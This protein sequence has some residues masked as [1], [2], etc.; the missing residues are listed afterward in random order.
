[1][2]K[3]AQRPLR[4][5][6][7]GSGPSAMYAAEALFKADGLDVRVDVFDRLP[8]PYGLVRGG[9][10][11]DHQKIKNVV[12]VYEKVES[13]PR[14]RFFGNVTLGRDVSVADLRAHYDQIVYAV[15]NES[16]R[17]MGIPGEDLDGVHSATDFVGW[18][19]GHPDY[20]DLEFKLATAQRVAIV[21]NGNVAVDVARILVRQPDELAPTDIA[22]Y[23]L[24][25]LR[26]SS[27]KDVVMLGRR[28]PAQAAF[29][30]KELQELADLDA[31]SVV[32]DPAEIELD[33]L[34]AEWLESQ[35]RSSK[36]N[37]EIL[38]DLAEVAPTAGART[39]HCRFLVSPVEF[40]GGSGIE[41]VRIEHGELV[42]DD[43]GTPRPKG[44]GKFEDLDVD[45]VFK[46]VGYRGV[47]IDGV[48]FDEGWGVIP[49]D[50][51]RVLERRDGDVVPNEYVVGWAKRGPTGLIGTNSPDAKDTVARMVED[52]TATRVW[53][54]LPGE[55]AIT[56]LLTRRGVEFVNLEDWRRLDAFEQ[57]QGAQR[58]KIRAK[59][60]SV[61]EMLKVVR[62]LRAAVS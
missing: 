40:A 17:K 18:Y 34:S 20:R 43:R 38:K 33:E 58:G 55:D 50:E 51:G 23:A 9:V 47:A 27:V 60:T 57:E 39:I 41:R 16:D 8:T 14:Y 7:V 26:A 6:I 28:G 53:D 59:L 36:R 29:S 15:G 11:P 25:A 42:A 4:V 32:V 44:T 35:P 45:L 21:G 3:S 37:V 1:M 22:D 61:E 24:S 30:P 46:A 19:N 62:E 10:A 54:D 52:V 31:V 13:D 2:A 56:D 12:R 49:N 5:A 48:P